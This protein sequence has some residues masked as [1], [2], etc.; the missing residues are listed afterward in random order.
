MFIESSIS[1]RSSAGR[2]TPDGERRRPGRQPVRY[3]RGAHSAGRWSR[4][5]RG[6]A[7]RA[8]GSG[9]ASGS[10]SGSGGAAAPYRNRLRRRA[11]RLEVEGR[12]SGQS[13]AEAALAESATS[14]VTSRRC[15]AGD[16]ASWPPS[17]PASAASDGARTSATCDP[18]DSDASPGGRRTG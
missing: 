15:A 16:G 9:G 13:G 6:V 1:V 14:A 17:E 4:G 7:G 3:A 11:A 18:A 5:G 12:S 2:R 8:G 10:G